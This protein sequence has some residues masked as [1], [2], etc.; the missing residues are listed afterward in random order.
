MDHADES[1]QTARSQPQTGR[2]NRR[3]G[4]SGFGAAERNQL[5]MAVRG[6]DDQLRFPLLLHRPDDRSELST[7]RMVRSGDANTLEVTGA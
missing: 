2:R 6:L 3:W 5:M 4:R 7:E 1:T